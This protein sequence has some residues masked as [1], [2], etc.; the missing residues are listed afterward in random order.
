MPPLLQRLQ[1]DHRQL[2]TLLN[3]LEKSLDR[4]HQGI[5]PNYATLAEAL[6]Y[7]ENYADQVHHPTEEMLVQS[8]RDQL[9]RNLPSPLEVLMRQHE[10][11]S[12][13]T[14]HF[15]QI[16]EG[17][18]QGEVLR[19]DVVEAQGRELVEVLRKHLQQEEISLFPLAQTQLREADW[20]AL[21]AQFAQRI[22]PLVDG[23]DLARFQALYQHLLAQLQP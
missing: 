23:Q 17:I 19:R 7:L 4:F 3:L 5:E 22:G 15:R 21:E 9:K 11:I 2:H 1:Q 14:G 16:L 8:L 20:Q 6:E 13:L 18:M 12:E 10:V